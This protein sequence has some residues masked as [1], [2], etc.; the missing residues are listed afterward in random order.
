MNRRVIG[1]V[2]VLVVAIAILIMA[3]VYHGYNV[4]IDRPDL[5][6]VKQVLPVDAEK[7]QEAFLVFAD[8][9][10][11]ESSNPEGLNFLD[12]TEE[13]LLDILR[14]TASKSIQQHATLALAK[15]RKLGAM[16][17]RDPDKRKQLMNET[18]EMLDKFIREN[19]DYSK[20]SDARFELVELLQGK[21]SFLHN[22]TDEQIEST[23][24]RIDDGL[25]IIIKDYQR[26]F[27]ATQDAD[28]REEIGNKIMRAYYTLGLNYYY[29]GLLSGKGSENREKYLKEAINSFN[30]FALNYS[31]KV[32]SYEAADF[33]GLFYYELGNYKNAKLYFKVTAVL[34]KSI[35]DDDQKTL[36]ERNEI[37]YECRDII[38]KAYAHLAMVAN[39]N[40]EHLEAIRIID[41]LTKMFPGNQSDEWMEMGLLEKSRS[42]FYTGD[43]EQALAMMYRLK[44]NSLNSSVREK[45]ANLL[46]EFKKP[47]GVK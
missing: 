29:R 42:I 15:L 18:I 14:T 3:V 33:I 11:E 28:K 40:N 43:K 26:M 39:G 21:A 36:D 12:I 47:E 31:E 27:D 46:R 23:Y 35:M 2:V 9:L 13:K 1:V 5:T 45:A 25:Y 10:T 34:Y 30:A 24:R 22:P 8:A 7:E 16:C 20:I 4:A 19:S 17:E 41:D 44:D 37:V 32:L 38:Q 6:P